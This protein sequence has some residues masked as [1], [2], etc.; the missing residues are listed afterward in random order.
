MLRSFV[1]ASVPVP[2]TA[3]GLWADVNTFAFIAATLPLFIYC[4]I[5]AVQHMDD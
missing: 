2:F 1:Y 3:L 5:Y 4:S